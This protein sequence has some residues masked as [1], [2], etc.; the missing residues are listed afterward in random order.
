VAAKGNAVRYGR[1]AA[2]LLACAAAGAVS[3]IAIAKS[4]SGAASAAYYYYCPGGG[5]GGVYGYCPPTTTTTTT[6]TTTP[7]P[8]GFMTGG[9]EFDPT[10]PCTKASFGGNASG[11]PGGSAKGHFNYVNH[12][13]G[14]HVNGPVT[15][16]LAVDP[17][18]RT[19]TFKVQVNASCTAIVTWRDAGEPGTNDTIEVTFS[20]ANCPPDQTTAAVK[21]DRGNIQWH[22]NV[23]SD[24]QASGAA[25]GVFPKG[26]VFQRLGLQRSRLGFGAVVGGDGSAVGQFQAELAGT[27][28]SGQ[29]RSISLEG[30][31]TRGSVGTGGSVTLS[32]TAVLR[33]DGA[34][35]V[36]LPFRVAATA[37]GLVLTIGAVELKRQTLKAGSI[38][39][40]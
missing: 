5:A 29:A 1:I 27:T 8:P 15:A 20:G 19:M 6:T 23:R 17:V 26:A 25:A 12:C 28:A 7:Q 31:V 33:V 4:S 13:T 39:V 32:G 37:T 18:T 35:P 21:L 38:F 10:G 40:G 36:T 2:T 24:V 3:S 14:V 30:N 11:Q 9:G 34:P 16:I 22:S